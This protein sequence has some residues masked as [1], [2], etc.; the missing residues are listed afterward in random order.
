MSRRKTSSARW[1]LPGIIVAVVGA[2][3]T[4][5]IFKRHS[6]DF[7]PQ[8]ATLQQVESTKSS[9]VSG[10]SGLPTN[11]ATTNLPGTDAQE[12]RVVALIAEGNQLVALGNYAEAAHKYEQA[13]NIS[14]DQE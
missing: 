5:V 10:T 2:G 14:P 8:V 11:V 6:R 1:W 7:K 3:L 4:I 13:V 9:P 12:D